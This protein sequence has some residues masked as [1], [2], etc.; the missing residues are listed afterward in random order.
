MGR[1]C[2]LVCAGIAAG[3]ELLL[4]GYLF[5]YLREQHG[6]AGAALISSV[7]FSLM[8]VVDGPR[9][10]LELL[11]IVA[12]GLVL[13][14]LRI[15]TGSLWAPIGFH[16]AWNWLDL[17]LLPVGDQGVEPFVATTSGAGPESDLFT[18]IAFVAVAVFF[19]IR[20]R[21]SLRP[22]AEMWRRDTGWVVAAWL[23][24][25]AA[26]VGGPLLFRGVAY[27]VV[28][29]PDEPGHLEL[30]SPGRAILPSV[31]LAATQTRAPLAWQRVTG[32]GVLVLEL[33]RPGCEGLAPDA[34]RDLLAAIAP[35][36]A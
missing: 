3:E 6:L 29:T 4:R 23:I 26:A 10:T 5:G 21:T 33:V 7:V 22:A 27:P 20:I 9:G 24:M 30:I 12:I 2:A 13:A 15:E 17:H 35:A 18:T 25:A 31:D 8:H 28:A 36:A 34:A 19:W 16:W 32:R 1:S 14:L 11:N